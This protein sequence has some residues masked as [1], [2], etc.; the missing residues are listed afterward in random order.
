MDSNTDIIAVPAQIDLVDSNGGDW[1][2]VYLN[3]TLAQ[4]GH[5]IEPEDLLNLIGV[6]YNSRTVRLERSGQLPQTLWQ[7]PTCEDH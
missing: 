3:G 6:P 4:Q 1:I 7:L 2:G 5:S